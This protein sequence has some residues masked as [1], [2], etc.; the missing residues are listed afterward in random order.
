MNC[1]PVLLSL[2]GNLG[3]IQETFQS[4]IQKLEQNGFH[5]LKQSTLFRSKAMGCEEGAPDFLNRSILGIWNCSPSG[6]LDLI[7]RIEVEAGRPADHPHWVSRPL[8]IDIILMGD[9]MLNTETLTVPHPELK[10]RDFVLIPSAEIA[11]GMK[12]PGISMSFSEL[13]LKNR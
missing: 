7:H 1:N 10:N 9:A 12:I 2:G 4:A 11:P 3:N 5:V 13:L 8:D 6:L